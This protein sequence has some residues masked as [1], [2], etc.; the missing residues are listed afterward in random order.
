MFFLP[1]CFRQGAAPVRSD[2]EHRRIDTQ[3]L[4]ISTPCKREEGVISAAGG[5][6]DR[7][8]SSQTPNKCSYFLPI[9]PLATVDKLT[10]FTCRLSINSGSLNLLQTSGPAQ[11]CIRI[12]FIYFLLCTV[13]FPFSGSSDFENVKKKLNPPPQTPNKKLDFK[14]MVPCIM[15]QC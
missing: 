15:L 9:Q 12:A 5:S 13:Y 7:I 8:V 3:I 6:S 11:A 4:A 1:R 10:T 2:L 14:L